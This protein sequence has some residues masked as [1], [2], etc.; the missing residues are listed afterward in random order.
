MLAKKARVMPV[1][2]IVLCRKEEQKSANKPDT[3]LNGKHHHHNTF[4]EGDESNCY[5]VAKA[6]I[7]TLAFCNH[8]VVV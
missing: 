1:E 7:S 4:V 3:L 8:G 2:G 6:A 5:R